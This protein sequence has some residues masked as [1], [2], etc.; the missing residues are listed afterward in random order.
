MATTKAMVG[1]VANGDLNT[2]NDT[3]NNGI[4]ARVDNAWDAARI[5][6]ARTSFDA[7]VEEE[8]MGEADPVDT[9]ITGDPAEVEEE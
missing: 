2:A 3:C 7:P 6:V 9:G 1:S 8:P 4:A 5:D